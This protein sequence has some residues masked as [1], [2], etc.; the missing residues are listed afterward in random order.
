LKKFIIVVLLLFFAACR[1]HPGGESLIDP[2]NDSKGLGAEDT[3]QIQEPIQLEDQDLN[4]GQNKSSSLNPVF[5]EYD[6]SSI[7]KDQVP[8]LI[9][10][11]NAMTQ[12]QPA[13]FTIE[14]HCDE[15]GTEEY[16][17]A[18]GDRRAKSAKDYLVSLGID[19]KRIHT[20]SYGE[21]HPF[22]NGHDEDAWRLNRRA[23]FVTQ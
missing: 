2:R 9:T 18:L 16:N 11:A 6:E 8:V 5:F 10:N 15:R 19:P 3:N 13:N 23:Q 21:S 20:I 17:L 22:E 1:H 12:T 4:A 7:E 14:G